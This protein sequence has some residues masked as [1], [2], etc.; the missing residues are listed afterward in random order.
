MSESIDVFP[1]SFAQQRVWFLDQLVPDSPLYNVPQAYRLSGPLDQEA[2]RR[3]LEDIASNH[4]T[5][6]TTF[7]P[8]EGVPVQKIHP[9]PSLALEVVDI[10][11][12][13]K[14]KRVEEARR[15]SSE[16][17]T[18]PFDLAQGPLMRAVLL[19]LGEEDHVLLLTF[20]HLVY[21]DWSE[22]VLWSELAAVYPAHVRGEP[23][24]LK[25]AEIQYADFSVWQ[26]EWLKEAALEPHL[27]YWRKQLERAPAALE[28]P[29]DR[30]RP[31]V[32]SHRG[33]VHRFS[34]SAEIT[35]GLRELSRRESA[36]LFMTLLAGFDV[37]LHRYT[38]QEDIVV[39]A[40]VAG[41][42]R[43]ELEGLIG[44]FVNT[45][46]LRCDLSEDPSFR[47]LVGRVR[48]VAL[49][50]YSHE[51]VPFEKLVEELRLERDLSRHPIFQVTFQ[52]RQH[53]ELPSLSEVSVEPLQVDGNL[54]K[55][56]LSL[57]VVDRE[58]TLEGV[59]EYPT[60]LFD[61]ETIERMATHFMVLLE[62]AMADPDLPISKLPLLTADERHQILYQWNETASEFPRDRCVHHLFEEQ[63]KETPDAT[64]VVFGEAELTY[65]GLNRRANQ[66]A[67][68]LMSLGVGPETLVGIC[69]ERSL[70]MV[71]GLLGILKAGGAYVPLDPNYP[72]E[73][74]GFMMRD[75]SV[76]VLVSQNDLL[77]RLPDHLGHVVLLDAHREVI[78]RH[79]AENPRSPVGP[80]N[81]AYVIYT[82]GSTGRPKGVMI[83]HR[84]M[85]NVV[86]WNMATVGVTPVDRESHL[87]T[88]SFDAS[89]LEFWPYL[90]AGAA[91]VVPGDPVARSSD[92]LRRWLS[93]NEVTAAFVPTVLAESL[94]DAD[95]GNG[96]TLRL[97]WTGGA[98]L[99]R[100]PPADL[101]FRVC[102]YYGPT[103]T[104]VVATASDVAATGT[105]S[106]PSIGRPIANTQVYALDSHMNPV[107]VGVVGEI[108]IGG[109]GVARGYLN[110][111]E[112]TE[113]RF[114][115]DPFGDDPE[116][117]L[118]RTGDLA[119]YLP[120]GNIE[121]IGRADDQVQ[122]RGLRVELGEIEANLLQ[123]LGIK[124]AVVLAREDSPGDKRLVAYLAGEGGAAPEAFDVRAFLKQ[125][126]PDYMLPQ[127][128][129]S[130]E[131]L[132]LTPNGKVDRDALPAPD[133]ARPVQE[134]PYVAPRNPLEELIAGIF[135]AVLGV[136]QVGIHDDFFDLGGHS[137]LTVRAVM[138]AEKKGVALT[139]DLIIQ[140]P[141]VAELA[142]AVTMEETEVVGSGL[143]EH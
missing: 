96:T 20:H 102:N 131:A 97:M 70:E 95:W 50:A 127:A 88:L 140:F 67:H 93:V 133:S 128:F 113:E 91:V 45:L 16:E 44:F 71:V 90:C 64:A 94:F 6:R 103:E 55:F 40:P 13:P 83:A 120:D 3:A 35:E 58:E 26:R 38:S 61:A 19:R 25:P 100:F 46:P 48:E 1:L 82:S 78:E 54:S 69:V 63:V 125:K 92:E 23:H 37:V 126:L 141:T 5:L 12:L 76:E 129:V 107:P 121:F 130:L 43:T 79:P 142:W 11:H 134:T 4:E 62:A 10:F 9:S 66:L 47:E 108:C 15:I 111:P 31:P 139:P 68:H 99:T 8:Q 109:T 29:A 7:E 85:V 98:K 21:D 105:G 51:D 119:R 136:E 57:H 114:V 137:L 49:G 53:S 72:P 110:R 33:A 34:V 32:Q 106:A 143:V 24:P 112:L 115:P 132:P 87:G 73:R 18:R 86:W 80:E 138:R 89:V 135:G 36:T 59:F 65:L 81:L 123:H 22:A 42:N 17:A 27:D 2:L 117:R 52:L 39:G 104:T 124:E 118:Y 116:A 75:A 41:R 122:I 28:L 60:D 14:G 74:L 101:P 84:S 56:D 77:D 30:P